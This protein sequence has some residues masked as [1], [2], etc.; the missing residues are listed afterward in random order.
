MQRRKAVKTK[1]E[2]DGKPA[3]K[4]IHPSTNVRIQTLEKSI[5]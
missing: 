1:P 3:G 4:C 2:A 5:T